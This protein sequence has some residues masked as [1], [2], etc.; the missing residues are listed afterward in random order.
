MAEISLVVPLVVAAGSALHC[1]SMCGGIAGA[2]TV[3]LPAQIQQ[4]RT[5]ALVYLLVAN[6]GR[7]ISYA[8]AGWLVALFG[9]SLFMSLSPR[10]GHTILESVSGVVLVLAGLHLGGHGTWLRRIEHLGAP[11]WRL[12]EPY[13]YRLMTS[14]GVGY[15]LTFGLIWGWLPCSLVYAALV[16]SSS[17]GTPADSALNMAMFGV[18]TC[19]VTLPAGWVIHRLTQW[20][21]RYHVRELVSMLLILAGMYTLF[22]ALLPIGRPLSPE[23]FQ[24]IGYCHDQ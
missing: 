18:G 15:M 20:A 13:A 3:S 12:L 5:N 9:Q 16:W 24:E 22:F 4:N 23:P 11:L 2:L 19:M 17:V 1:L 21:M 8:M 14:H 6:G 10:Y 7:V